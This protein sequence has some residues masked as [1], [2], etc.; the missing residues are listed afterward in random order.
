LDEEIDSEESLLTLGFRLKRFSKEEVS[1][2]EK[3]DFSP[4]L[5]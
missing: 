1:C 5:S 4:L 3:E 2:I